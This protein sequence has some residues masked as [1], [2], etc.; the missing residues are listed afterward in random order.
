MA[1]TIMIKPV[2]A[3]LAIGLV[4]T[5]LV[6][7]CGDSGDTTGGTTGTSGQGC[8][9]AEGCPEVTSDCISFVDNSASDVFALR[10]SGLTISSPTAL[11]DPTITALL[12]NAVNL[13]YPTCK[14]ATGDS[15]YTGDGTFSWILQF[16][17]TAG[18]LTTG[19][20]VLEADPTK[21]YC[22]VNQT[23][24]GFMVNPLVADAPIGADGSFAIAETRDVVVPV[25]TTPGDPNTVILLPL[26]GVRLSGGKVSAD[27]NCIGTY[28]SAEL[29]PNNLC[30]PDADTPQFV[31][32]SDLEAYMTLE[33][34][35]AVTVPVLSDVSLCTLL[36]G[37]PMYVDGKVCKRTGGVI[38][39][40]GDWCAGAAEGDPGTAATATCKDAVRLQAKLTASGVAMRT[41]CP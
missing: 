37:D 21:G 3:A 4:S 17:K 40:P 29:E 13:D 14:A 19:G 5:S 16:D 24:N 36:A 12:A 1:P 11:T 39:F 28:N 2:S 33:E 18:T 9:P 6:V 34:A 41:D 10:I 22:F 25:Y 8:E 35:D 30:L 7:A 32:G 31:G 20:A 27:N 23:I 26:Q 15:I 38:D